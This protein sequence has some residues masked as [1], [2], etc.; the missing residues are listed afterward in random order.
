MTAS[1]ITDRGRHDDRLGED[2]EAAVLDVLRQQV[3]DEPGDDGGRDRVVPAPDPPGKADDQP[4]EA[5]QPEEP[6][7]PVVGEVVG[8][9]QPVAARP[10]PEGLER[11]DDVAELAVGVRDVADRARLD[12]VDHLRQLDQPDDDQ[13]DR[14]RD[15]D[16]HRG[17]HRPPHALRTALRPDAE[18]VGEQ[19][20][21]AVIAIQAT[22]GRL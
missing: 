15:H 11:R 19:P 7:D 9:E 10:D 14:R 2:V 1:S 8:A 18:Q 4:G 12:E 13:Q 21:P 3:D 17:A 6:V 5:D 22:P 20:E 16:R